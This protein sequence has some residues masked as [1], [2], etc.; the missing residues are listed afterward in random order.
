[1][2]TKKRSSKNELMWSG[3]IL[4]RSALILCQAAKRADR[5]TQQ[6]GS[7]KLS[8]TPTLDLRAADRRRR[9]GD[10]ECLV[11]LRSPEGVESGVATSPNMERAKAPGADL[12]P[13]PQSPIL[14]THHSRHP[15]SLPNPPTKP[16]HLARTTKFDAPAC[17]T[18]RVGG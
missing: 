3:E 15:P 11:S 14:E 8:R 16:C 10:T 7:A 13:S 5:R 18:P 17:Q 12:I 4:C 1:M 9:R 6:R 2:R